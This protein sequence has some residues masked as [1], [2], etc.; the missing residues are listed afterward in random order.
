MKVVS[1]DGGPAGVHSQSDE[2][3][4]SSHLLMAMI[5]ACKIIIITVITILS[6]IV[7]A[8]DA[9]GQVLLGYMQLQPFVYILA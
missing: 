9:C 3:M 7:I 8:I 2:P 6:V 4:V 5:G 1:A